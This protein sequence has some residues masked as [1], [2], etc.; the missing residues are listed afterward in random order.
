MGKPSDFPE[1]TAKINTSL[2][3]VNSFKKSLDIDLSRLSS[4]IEI[5]TIKN[6]QIQKFEYTLELVWKTLKSILYSVHGVDLNTPKPVI[7]EYAKLSNLTPEEIESMLAMI[8]DR[9]RITHEYKDHIMTDVY[10]KLRD[11]LNSIEKICT[12]FEQ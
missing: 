4:E 2:Q 3:A 5:D 1:I 12:F 6:G 9:N 10:P 8:D 11:Y 7:R